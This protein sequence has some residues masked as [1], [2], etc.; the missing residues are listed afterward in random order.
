ME[1]HVRN[2]VGILKKIGA[3]ILH[4]RIIIVDSMDIGNRISQVILNAPFYISVGDL[5]PLCAHQND[6]ITRFSRLAYMK[7]CGMRYFAFL[8]KCLTLSPPD[9]C[10]H[11]VGWESDEKNSDVNADYRAFHFKNY[12]D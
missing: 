12:S 6:D 9:F 5:N 2:T 3:R 10:G 1:N 11:G 4:C 8:S 7:C